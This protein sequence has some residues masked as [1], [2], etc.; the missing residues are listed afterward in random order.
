MSPYLSW[1]LSSTTTAP[2]PLRLASQAAWGCIEPKP[3]FAAP[4]ILTSGLYWPY[5][6][7]KKLNR[8]KSEFL[9]PLSMRNKN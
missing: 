6:S 8:K 5:S 9:V 4:H 3:Q 1:Q 7:M 2:P